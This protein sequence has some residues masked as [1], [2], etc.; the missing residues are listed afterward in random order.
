MLT[1]D[2]IK[3]KF[4]NDQKN[5]GQIVLEYVLLLV[6]GVGIAAL[7]TVTMVNR[8]PENPGFLMAKWRAIIQVIATDTADDLAP[9][10]EEQ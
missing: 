8:N 10:D 9:E 6:I 1:P 3:K 4:R 2:E 5:K 7:I